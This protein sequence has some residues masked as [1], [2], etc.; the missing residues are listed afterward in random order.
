MRTSV[1]LFIASLLL[2]LL[3]TNQ[4]EGTVFSPTHTAVSSNTADW[5]ISADRL[6]S[7]DLRLSTDRQDC[8]NRQI[9]TR[10]FTCN[11]SQ[12]GKGYSGSV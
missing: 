3:V 10:N 5:Q 4:T 9:S 11:R 2:L 12:E 8:A 1:K 6:K 7:M